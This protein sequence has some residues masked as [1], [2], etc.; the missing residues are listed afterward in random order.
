MTKYLRNVD[1]ERERSLFVKRMEE[2]VVDLA[3]RDPG[4][5][6]EHVAEA[7]DHLSWKLSHELAS[8]EEE[9]SLSTSMWGMGTGIMGWERIICRYFAGTIFTTIGY[10]DVACATFTGRMATVLYAIFGSP[11]CS[12][13]D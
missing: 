1:Y 6:R 2:I 7:V 12:L 8:K 13:S 10:G 4:R 9:W 3:A 5:R 11:T